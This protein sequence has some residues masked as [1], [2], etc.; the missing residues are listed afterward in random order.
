MS[1][2]HGLL[3]KLF[4]PTLHRSCARTTGESDV[5]AFLHQRLMYNRVNNSY[6]CQ[7]SKTQNGILKTEMGFQGYV[8]S[9]WNA[10]HGGVAPVLAGLDSEL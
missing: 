1:S 2:M 9:D 5:G 10:V 7:N 3:R 8:M 6:A 4:E